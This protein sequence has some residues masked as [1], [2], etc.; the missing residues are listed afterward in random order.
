MAE[1]FRVENSELAITSAEA[2]HKP[3]AFTIHSAR[4]LNLGTARTIAFSSTLP[5]PEPPGE[6]ETHGWLGPFA[7]GDGGARRT[8]INGSYVFAATFYTTRA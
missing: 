4:F 1:E 5:I 6:A 8:P 3:L 2:G 7:T